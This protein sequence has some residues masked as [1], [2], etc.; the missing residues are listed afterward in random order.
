MGRKRLGEILLESGA[1]GADGLER[2]LAHARGRGIRLGAALQELGLVPEDRLVE[3]LASTLGLPIADLG[4]DD[5]DWEALHLLRPEFCETH[6]LL[7]YALEEGRGRGL[8]L[9]AMADPLDVPAIDEIEFTTGR[10]VRPAVAG[11][12]AIHAAIAR[13]IRRD[14]PRPDPSGQ[15]VLVRAGGVQ[16]VFDPGP[17]DEVDVVSLV[18]VAEGP[19]SPPPPPAPPPGRFDGTV[20]SG[21]ASGWP[22]PPPS[23][24]QPPAMPLPAMPVPAVPP[25][26][27]MIAPPPA[28]TGV[29]PGSVEARLARLEDRQRFLVRR[30]AERGLLGDDELRL[31]LE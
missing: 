5:L 20:S 28:A 29:A 22:W 31:L 14:R 10:R 7:P 18:E 15:V 19:R 21:G 13:W 11:R 25:A 6:E 30:L 1:I 16:E 26:M 8:L 23:S 12:D 2:A 17:G 9:V 3:A 4:A 24:P 27:P